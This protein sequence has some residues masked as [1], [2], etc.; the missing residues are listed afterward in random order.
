MGLSFC[1]QRVFDGAVAPLFPFL[2]R[3]GLCSLSTLTW[4]RQ[5]SPCQAELGREGGQTSASKAQFPRLKSEGLKG[6]FSFPCSNLETEK[7]CGE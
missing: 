7:L 5:E 2:P 1:P 3:S 4:G 6:T